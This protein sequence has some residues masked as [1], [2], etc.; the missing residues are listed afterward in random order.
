MYSVGLRLSHT[1]PTAAFL[2][3]AVGWPFELSRWQLPGNWK[4][5]KH[6]MSEE[7]EEGLAHPSNKVQ[8]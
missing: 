8:R 4:L 2:E 3:N 6:P 7:A 5:V 1:S